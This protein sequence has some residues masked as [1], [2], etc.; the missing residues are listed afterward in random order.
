MAVSP[1]KRQE[2]KHPASG[3]PSRKSL[4]VGNEELLPLINVIFYSS[5]L[6]T[7]PRGLTEMTTSQVEM[8]Q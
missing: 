3:S 1:L 4:S 5:D 2:K 8:G 6:D 7:Q